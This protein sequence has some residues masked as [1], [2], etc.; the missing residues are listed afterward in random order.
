MKSK[1]VLPVYANVPYLA[2]VLSTPEDFSTT[3]RK[4]VEQSYVV[5]Y[6]VSM[7]SSTMWSGET[8]MFHTHTLLDQ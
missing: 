7:V 1:I 4:V 6:S 8:V 2:K 3:S 5:W